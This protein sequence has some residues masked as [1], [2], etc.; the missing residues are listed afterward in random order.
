MAETR[1]SFYSLAEDAPG[2]RFQLACRLVERIYAAGL[3][4]YILAASDQEARHLDRLLWTFREQSFIP[5]GLKGE[6]DADLTPIL[7]GW[8]ADPGDA[9]A[10]LINLSGRVPERLERFERLC[11][12]VDQDPAIRDAAR[13]RFRH[14]RRAGLSLEHHQIRLS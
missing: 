2:D 12:A 8:D 6:T 11:E 14:Y 1:V 9:R 4:V 3:R 7:I 13:E 5:H 10:V